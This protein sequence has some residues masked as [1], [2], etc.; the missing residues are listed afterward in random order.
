LLALVAESDTVAT[1]V[2]ERLGASVSK[3]RGRLQQLL[4]RDVEASVENTAI[5][6][7]AV[8]LS[9]RSKRVLDWAYD[10][11]RRSNTNYIGTEH[12]LLGIVRECDGF[13]FRTLV[14]PG[15]DIISCRREV[16]SYLGGEMPSDA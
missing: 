14:K 5:E 3:M 15:V 8:A 11:A 9:P 1:K 2:L 12:L 6:R 4:N 13:A 7:T 16:V 10:E